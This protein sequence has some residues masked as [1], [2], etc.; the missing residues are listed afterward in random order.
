[1]GNFYCPSG[2][3]CHAPADDGLDLGIDDLINDEKVDYGIT[4]FDN[5]GI[6]LITV[7]QMITLEGWSKIMYNLM[8]SN[9]VWMAILFSIFLIMI[10][11]FF[12]LNVVLAVLAEAL[13][14]IEKI[15]QDTDAKQNSFIAK[16]IY[17]RKKQD[18]KNGKIAAE[19]LTDLENKQSGEEE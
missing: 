18:I 6:G 12:L 3:F 7:F 5:L 2:R 4:V 10:G 16:S 13:E 8:D 9:I 15:Q 11:S 1:M 19:F 17:R 14:N